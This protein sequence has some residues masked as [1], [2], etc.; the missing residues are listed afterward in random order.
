MTS[1][2]SWIEGILPRACGHELLSFAVWVIYSVF[3][4]GISKLHLL[5]LLVVISE[6]STKKTNIFS[7][8]SDICLY[9]LGLSLA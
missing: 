3:A 4:L 7:G 5:V 8:C 9:V 2:S 1:G 6:E